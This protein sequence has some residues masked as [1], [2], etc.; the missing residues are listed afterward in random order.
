MKSSWLRT[1]LKLRLLVVVF[2]TGCVHTTEP[3]VSDPQLNNAT[4]NTDQ[5]AQPGVKDPAMVIYID[6]KTGEIIVP[7]KG[8]LPG[9]VPQS[10]LDTSKKPLP[11]LPQTLSPVPGGGVVIHLD[12]RFMNPLTATIDAEGKVRQ[13]HK[14]T[15]SGSDEK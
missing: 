9:Q 12:E 14:Q 8:A 3:I 1:R 15:M 6:P 7:S 2:V 13:E 5:A 11:D 10:A 4:G